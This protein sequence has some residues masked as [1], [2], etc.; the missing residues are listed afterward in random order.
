MMPTSRRKGPAVN[1]TITENPH[2]DDIE[3]SV[4]CPRIDERAQ[5]IV[6]SLSALDHQLVGSHG[7]TT[8]RVP[9]DDVLYIETVDGATFLY[10]ANAVLETPLRLYEAEDRLSG[11]EF[12]RAS[13]QM[14]V[15]FDHVRGI[16]PVP[17]ARLQL[18]LD[19]GEAAIASR[20]YAPDIKRKLGL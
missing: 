11:T 10:T 4:A 3:V 19:N 2:L 1:V 9:L 14:L 12:V 7:G 6:A 5:R 13:R 18:L 15:N 17:G 16:R 8:Y 20:Q